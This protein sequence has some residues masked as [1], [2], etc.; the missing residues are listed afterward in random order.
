MVWGES[1][2]CLVWISTGSVW[3]PH[4]KDLEEQGQSRTGREPGVKTKCGRTIL[5]DSEQSTMW[6]DLHFQNLALTVS[7]ELGVEGQ[8][9][10][11]KSISGHIAVLQAGDTVQREQWDSVGRS[12]YYYFLF[13]LNFWVTLINKFLWV[14]GVHF[15]NSSSVYCIV[16]PSKVSH[17][18]LPPFTLSYLF[19]P[20]F[21]LVITAWL[22][23]RFSGGVCLLFTISTLFSLSPQLV[24]DNCFTNLLVCF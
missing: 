12:I 18:H 1:E 11:W 8:G 9:W 23:K 2:L 5:K 6:C 3:L 15:Y 7:G 17:S 4:G 14:S 16:A 21:L 19:A 22:S 13:L 24:S 20:P 10:S